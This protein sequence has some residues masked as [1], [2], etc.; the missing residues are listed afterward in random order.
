[1]KTSEKKL[2]F[3]DIKLVKKIITKK[4]PKRSRFKPKNSITVK[5]YKKL[6][7]TI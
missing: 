2:G 6:S 3:A 1:M 5:S 4:I 7:K